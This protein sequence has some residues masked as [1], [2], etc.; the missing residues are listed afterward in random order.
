MTKKKT[1]IVEHADGGAIVVLIDHTM[2]GRY[3]TDDPFKPYLHPVRTI[4]GRCVTLAKPHDHRHHKGIMYALTATDVNWWEEDA[5]YVTTVG[6]QRQ[7]ST[8]LTDSGI[9]QELRWTATDGSLE[10]FHERRSIDCQWHPDGF[11]RWTW[12]SEL[13]ALRDLAL[14]HS[15]YA[16][17]SESGAPINYHGLGIR[18]P[19]S[20]GGMS[21]GTTWTADGIPKRPQT[22]NGTHPMQTKISDLLDGDFPPPRV[23]ITVTQPVS[24]HAVFAVRDPFSYFSI[25]P[26]VESTLTLTAGDTLSE[27]YTIDVADGGPSEQADADVHAARAESDRTRTARHRRTAKRSKAAP[28][29]RNR[30]PKL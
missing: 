24:T 9:R 7:E 29:F 8:K 13:T 22:I 14:R 15:P 3:E 20:F 2:V 16:V 19:R 18:F 26:T 21:G 30:G 5:S 1:C 10:S 17:P 12:T 25:G 6:M 23:T 4:S 28:S 11:I 27:T